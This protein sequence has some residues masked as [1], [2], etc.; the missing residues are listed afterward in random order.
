MSTFRRTRMTVVMVETDDY[1][2]KAGKFPDYFT[3]QLRYGK[4]RIATAYKGLQFAGKVTSRWLR[5]KEGR[6]AI[7]YFAMRSKYFRIA[8]PTAAVGGGLIYNGLKSTPLD[9]QSTYK[10]RQTRNN[11]VKYRTKRICYPE[12]YPRRRRR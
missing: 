3:R 9:G 5:T 7:R 4:G 1:A 6:Q 11:M 12:R 8:A 2:K 10:I